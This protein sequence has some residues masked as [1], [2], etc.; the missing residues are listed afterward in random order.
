MAVGKTGANNNKPKTN[1]KSK[2][3]NTAKSKGSGTRNSKY[4]PPRLNR[5]EPPVSK[6]LKDIDFKR[7]TAMNVETGWLDTVYFKDE[8]KLTLKNS[9][10]ELVLL[11]LDMVYTK[12]PTKFMAVLS[13]N[14]VLSGG[15]TVDLNVVNHPATSDESYVTYRL[16]S[17]PYYVEFLKDGEAILKALYGLFKI[18]GIDWKTVKFTINPLIVDGETMINTYSGVRQVITVNTLQELMDKG[19][20]DVEACAI[21]IF[22]NKQEVNDTK[23]AMLMMFMWMQMTYSP[24]ELKQSMIRNTNS[25]I[26]LTTAAKIEDYGLGTGFN[27]QRILDMH[28]YFTEYKPSL[29]KYMYNVASE[30]GIPP[31]LI[32]I[33]YKELK[34]EK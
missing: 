18:T 29:Y 10:E 30:C 1:S 26:G 7:V 28:M 20:L 16:G 2:T 22:G 32:E 4:V 11:M 9:W 21:S 31:A 23:Q 6:I 14:Y 33:E 34:L 3:K 24:E 5:D 17:S 12:Y 25:E 8:G 15:L 19:K 13:D 27:T